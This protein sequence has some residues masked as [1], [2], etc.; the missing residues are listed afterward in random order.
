VKKVLVIIIT[1]NGASYIRKCLETIQES[2]IDLS[3]LVIDNGSK[4]E[5]IKIL[6]NEF[7]GINIILNHENLGFGKAN[8]IGLKYAID[9]NFQ[10]VFLINQDAYVSSSA[11]EL[12]LKNLELHNEY[13]ILSPMHLNTEGSSF[14]IKFSEY[15]QQPYCENFISDIFFNRVRP[16]YNSTFVN[17]AAWLVSVNAIKV[18]GG[19]DPIFFHY[20]EDVDFV[21]RCK[22][23]NYKIG[24]CPTS[25]IIHDSK[26]TKWSDILWNKSRM[27]TIYIT[28]IKD[29]NGSI[30]SNLLIFLKRR[31]NEITDDLIYGRFKLC[32]LRIVLCFSV[33]IKLNHIHI[34]RQK[35]KML[36]PFI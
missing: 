4:D 19:F 10:Y 20:G 2:S 36:R 9:N 31:F 17:A 35:S 26:N 29:V 3:I 11:I 8:N 25:V 28:E 15:I 16:V 14:E 6:E 24:F 5:T 13:A 1:Y 30:R 21:Q 23:R 34:S 32:R 27:I 18:I 12:L 7:Y 22:Y 33:L